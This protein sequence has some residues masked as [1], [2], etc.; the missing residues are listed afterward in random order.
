MR[1]HGHRVLVTG[2]TTGI[3]RGLTEEF[4]RRGNTVAV[5]AR[6]SRHLAELTES[7]PACQPIEADLTD[8]STHAAVID[9]AIGRLGGL[10]ILVN[11]AGVQY[12]HNYLD[13]PA[14]KVLAEV[15]REL[16]LNL[17]ALISL[18]VLALPHL[19]QA[20][21]AAIVNVSSIL[22]FAPKRSA[23]VYCASKA[24]VHSFTRALRYQVEREAPAIRV[25]DIQPPAVYTPM[26]AAYGRKDQMLTVDEVTRSVF[27]GLE[28]DQAEIPLGKTRSGR[29]L[30][31]LVPNWTY[32]RFRDG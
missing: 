10:S 32:R 3:G 22:A 13:D 9:Q 23:P 5:V 26:T 16:A 7:W 28:R 17:D 18:S 2:G 19:R 31:R 21:E 6:N 4:I 11:N 30:L 8:P 29:W 15:R 12:R 27:R 1:L 25:V 24:A 14:E 20:D